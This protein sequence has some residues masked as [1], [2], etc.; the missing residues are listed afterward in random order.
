M[1]QGPD[2]DR[3]TEIRTLVQ[4]LYTSLNASEHTAKMENELKIQLDDIKKQLEP[5]EKVD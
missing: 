5:L 4:Q 2:L 1:L 3:L